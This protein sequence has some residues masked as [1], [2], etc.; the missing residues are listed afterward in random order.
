MVGAIPSIGISAT[1]LA[2]NGPLS[3]SVWTHIKAGWQSTIH[4]RGQ[5]TTTVY[6]HLHESEKRVAGKNLQSTG[7]HA[8]R[9]SFPETR[10][11]LQR[12]TQLCT[13]RSL[14]DEP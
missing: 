1:D 14:P 2:P 9:R 3:S 10:C 6:I 4:P 12:H 5:R 7:F 11:A 13:V 8:R